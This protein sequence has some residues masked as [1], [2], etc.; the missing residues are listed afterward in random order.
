MAASQLPNQKPVLLTT[1]PWRQT[2]FKSAGRDREVD[3]EASRARDGTLEVSTLA[4]PC[5]LNSKLCQSPE[6]TSVAVAMRRIS[7]LGEGRGAA[8]GRQG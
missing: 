6:L 8:W 2:P 4:S 5:V 7:P 1:G 3:M